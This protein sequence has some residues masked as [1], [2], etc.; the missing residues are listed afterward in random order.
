[1]G[2]DAELKRMVASPGWASPPVRWRFGKAAAELHEA[3]Q[4]YAAIGNRVGLKDSD[5]RHAIAFA[6]VCKRADA[7]RLKKV[8]WRSVLTIISA[9]TEHQ[10]QQLVESA[11]KMNSVE[12]QALAKRLK[13]VPAVPRFRGGDPVKI[14]LRDAAHLEALSA[15][16]VNQADW[17]EV[18]PARRRKI[19]DRVAKLRAALTAVS[20]AL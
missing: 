2:A 4:S 12:L 5:V 10:R 1:M 20:G 17:A 8:P 11:T 9:T 3:G 13:R 6:H 18:S 16:L 7:Q 15:Q 14:W 19:A